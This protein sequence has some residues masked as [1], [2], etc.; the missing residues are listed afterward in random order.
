MKGTF[1]CELFPPKSEKGMSALAAAVG[2][3]LFFVLVVLLR[4]G[5]QPILQDLVEVLLDV[6]VGEQF[7]FVVFVVLVALLPLG[8]WCLGGGIAV[9]VVIVVGDVVV[10]DWDDVGNLS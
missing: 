3:F 9:V 4:G 7:V 2:L 5:D 8:A 10:G 1:S 6:V